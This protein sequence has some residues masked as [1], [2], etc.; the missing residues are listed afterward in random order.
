MLTSGANVAADIFAGYGSY[1]TSSPTLYYGGIFA[2]SVNHTP[3]PEL[4]VPIDLLLRHGLR[5]RR[6]RA[7]PEREHC[8]CEMVIN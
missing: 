1:E 2:D 3:R 5:G 7:V 4:P 6:G 8:T